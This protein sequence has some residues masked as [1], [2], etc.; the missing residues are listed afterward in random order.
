MFEKRV[1]PSKTEKRLF[2]ESQVHEETL[3]GSLFEQGTLMGN[4]MYR[5]NWRVSSFLHNR[6]S[7]YIRIDR[8]EVDRLS[9]DNLRRR[10]AIGNQTKYQGLVEL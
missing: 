10:L 5:R 6:I 4:M 7:G 3:S 8:L 2:V 9:V 1:L